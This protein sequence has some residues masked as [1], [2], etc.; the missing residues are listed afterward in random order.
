MSRA[1]VDIH[2]D[3]PY[4]TVDGRSLLL[5][6]YLPEGA[7]GDCP[8][9]LY[10][11][12]GAFMVGSKD[13]NA[14]ER[15]LPVARSGIAI[16]SAE[17]RFSDVA[18]Y[19]A[20]VH[21]VKAA[22]RW[23]RCNAAEYGWRADR[24]GAWG[25]SA[26]GYLALM[27]GLTAGSDEHE[28]TLGEHLDES[29]S[30]E[31]VTAWFAVADLPVADLGP[32]AGRVLPPFIVG[33]PPRPSV[34]ARF[35]GVQN[36]AEE[37]KLALSASPAHRAVGAT[38]AFLLMHGDADGLVGEDQSQRMHA[39]LTTAGVDS[40]LLMIVGANHEDAAFHNP[41]VLGAVAGF[42]TE[43]LGHGGETR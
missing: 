5:D 19:P 32:P 21:D 41:A 9:V 6:L 43:K 28:G 23:L 8:V 20:Q 1:R 22:V 34:L 36:V 25:A 29:S 3:L 30:V 18:S 40:T 31:A 11:H 39:A 12:G 10:L 37:V 35:L 26:G 13:N 24:V 42:F 27:L 38:A 2:R 15:L 33:P 14:Q 7:R 17:Y 16:A 4:A